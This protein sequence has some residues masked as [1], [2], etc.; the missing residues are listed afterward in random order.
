VQVLYGDGLADSDLGVGAPLV[1]ALI[2]LQFPD[3]DPHNVSLLGEGCDSRAFD[4]DGRWV[5]RFPKRADVEQQLLLESRVLPVLAN[6]SPLPLPLFRFHGRPSE[7]FPWH[8]VGY[9]KLPGVPGIQLSAAEFP[10]ERWA[11]AVGRFLSWLHRF[12]VEDARLLE[13]EERPVADLIEEVRRDALD[14][15]HVVGR[16][17]QA[18][19]WKAFFETG[20]PTSAL[21]PLPSVVVHSDLAVEHILFDPATGEVTGIID[22]TEI[23]LGDP[24]VDL[25]CF[26]HW[27]GAPAVASALAHYDGRCDGGVLAR[28]RFLAACRAVGDVA[29]GSRTGRSEYVEAGMRALRFCVR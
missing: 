29:Y 3:I 25:A 5:F 9:P 15:F 22:W 13:L 20:L 16:A 4:V 2:R 12:P 18:G 14:D 10:L 7:M 11:P 23:A 1:L 19:Q 21:N 6:A 26:Y 8:F 28:A 17:P 24:S 27:G